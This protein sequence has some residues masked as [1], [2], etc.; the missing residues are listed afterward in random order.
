MEAEILRCTGTV[1]KGTVGTEEQWV[2]R[3]RGTVVTEVQR[4]SGHRG[5]VGTEEQWVQRDS[6]F[7][8]TFRHTSFITVV[9]HI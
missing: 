3:Y 6:S 1:S 5:I 7:R 9:C 8:G 4:S 2:Q